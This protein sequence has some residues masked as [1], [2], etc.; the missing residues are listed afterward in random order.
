MNRQRFVGILIVALLLSGCVTLVPPEEYRIQPHRGLAQPTADNAQVVFLWTDN[1][2]F[3]TVVLPVFEQ[4]VI[5]G[6]L[7]GA[8]YYVHTVTPG[9]YAFAMDRG[10]MAEQTS[11]TMT[12]QAGKTYFVLYSPP[13][14]WTQPILQLIPEEVALAQLPHLD[15]IQLV[16]R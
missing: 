16:S 11:V 8:T 1:R 5:I 7:R 9:R 3:K 4:E 6:A 15:R 10:W 2:Q 13:A 14:Q 12:A